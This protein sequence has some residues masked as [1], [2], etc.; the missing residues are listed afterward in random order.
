MNAGDV[1]RL[2]EVWRAHAG[3]HV[4]ACEWSRD[5]QHAVVGSIAGRLMLLER[6]T[7]AVLWKAEAHAAG[8][9]AAD[10]HPVT[11]AVAT[12]GHD[13]RLCLW[14]G[15]TG[16]LT[17]TCAAAALWG[18]AVQWS[19]D[20]RWL[21][22]AAG[23]AV[24]VWTPEGDE[25]RTWPGHRATVA[26]LVWHPSD[27]QLCAA[28][29][30]GLVILAPD[31]QKP[32]RTLNW[33]GSSLVARWSPDGKYIV[34]GEQD[35]SVHFWITA[36]GKDLQMTGYPG[37]VLELSWSPDSRWLATGGG[38]EVCIW[39][40][41]GK[42]PKGTTPLVV[43]GH[44]DRVSAVAFHPDGRLLASG[45]DDGQVRMWRVD[46]ADRCAPA[47]ALDLGE[48]VSQLVWSPDG[49][50]VLVG[51]ARGAVWLVHPG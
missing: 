4:V 51:G 41:G 43:S 46:G 18:M 30:G 26:D 45:S 11:S 13:G 44:R 5:G 47:G 33:Q 3:D 28:T 38:R 36:T 6:A 22:S 29:Y 9:A 19:A 24:Q 7:S 50:D 39:H 8:L 15:L 31:A 49:R 21:A 17:R 12:I 1:T 14:D 23:R 25:H 48:P 32:L 27:A 34:T 35:S 16:T 20:G 42:G 40:C 2:F 10:W 37:K